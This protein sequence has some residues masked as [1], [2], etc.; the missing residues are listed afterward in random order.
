MGQAD[1]R[2]CTCSARGIYIRGCVRRCFRLLLMLTSVLCKDQG[3]YFH[4]NH[5]IRFV[6]ISGPIVGIR[7]IPDDSASVP[8]FVILD[9]DDSSGQTIE[10][11]VRTVKPRLQSVTN[12]PK[13]RIESARD[14]THHDTPSQSS[15][16]GVDD[17]LRH[18]S[19]LKTFTADTNIEN[20]KITNACSVEDCREKHVQLNGHILDIHTV[21]KAKGTITS[22]NDT[23][24][25]ELER[26]FVVRTTDEELRIWEEYTAFCMNALSK[27][28]KLDKTVLRKMERMDRERVSKAA[29]ENRKKEEKQRLRDHKHERRR[30]RHRVREA[31]AEKKRQ[32]ERAELDGNA[33]DWPRW[34]PRPVAHR[35]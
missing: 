31:E 11:K 3:I 32:S 21:I 28:W 26:A 24:Q 23:R 12:R 1:R 5:P 7:P 34:K 4:L 2:G 14:I 33:L 35:L 10:V 19:T 30:E 16:E 17:Q 20:I 9:I 22:Y 27:P 6:Y 25:I 8:Y 29:L 15:D 13:Q 18:S